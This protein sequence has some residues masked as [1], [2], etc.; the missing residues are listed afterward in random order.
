LAYVD[1][2]EAVVRDVHVRS[3]RTAQTKLATT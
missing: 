1:E 2:L 3:K